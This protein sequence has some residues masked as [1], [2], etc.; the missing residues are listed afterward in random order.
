MK[1]TPNEYPANEHRQRAHAATARDVF[2]TAGRRVKVGFAVG[3][4]GQ[5]RV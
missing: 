4:P 3:Q 2:T 5:W 1:A